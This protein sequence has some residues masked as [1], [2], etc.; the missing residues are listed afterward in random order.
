M[1]HPKLQPLPVLH[2][3]YKSNKCLY[4]KSDKLS[5]L[6]KQTHLHSKTMR[7][8]PGIVISVEVHIDHKENNNVVHVCVCVCA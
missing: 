2:Y 1:S 4:S 3:S 5:A 7:T 8:S 6:T